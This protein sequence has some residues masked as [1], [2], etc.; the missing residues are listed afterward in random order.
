MHAHPCMLAGM[1]FLEVLY[2]LY[3]LDWLIYIIC[4]NNSSFNAES[5]CNSEPTLTED[6]DRYICRPSVRLPST[7]KHSN[8][9]EEIT[10]AN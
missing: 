8:L 6:A 9:R 3:S 4:P 2:M 1:D 7:I 5:E 10:T